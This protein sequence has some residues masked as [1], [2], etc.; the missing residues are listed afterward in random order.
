MDGWKKFEGCK[1]YIELIS[2]RKYTGIVKAVDDKNSPVTFIYI[3][4]KFGE[5][6][7]FPVSEI[8]LIQEEK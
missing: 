7:I 8:K 1:V 3:E 5:M 6:V 4:D 2:G